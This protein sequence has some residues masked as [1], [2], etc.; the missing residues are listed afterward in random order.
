MHPVDLEPKSL[1]STLLLKEG[2]SFKLKLI[3]SS[4]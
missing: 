1:P 4:K 3:K 2:E